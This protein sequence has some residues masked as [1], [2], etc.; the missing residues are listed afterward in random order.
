MGEGLSRECNVNVLH[1]YEKDLSEE[2]ASPGES[3]AKS[4][5]GRARVPAS[6]EL[7][8]TEQEKANLQTKILQMR[9]VSNKFYW[10]AF[11]IGN[12]AFIEFCGLMNDYINTCQDALNEGIDFTNCN[13]HTGSHLPLQNHQRKYLS[14]KLTCIYGV[15]LAEERTHT[16]CNSN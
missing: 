15:G 5:G 11:G 6:C 12:H 14:E 2:S 1:L 16:Q 7:N 8:M 4:S 10:A 9:Q 3:R 13:V